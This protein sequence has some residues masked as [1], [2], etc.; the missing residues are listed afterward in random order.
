MIVGF[1]LSGVIARRVA[2]GR[3]LCVKT[4]AISDRVSRDVLMLESPS[5]G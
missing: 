2:C 3:W 1:V 4:F 5:E